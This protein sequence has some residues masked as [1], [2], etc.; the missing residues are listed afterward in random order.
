M[1]PI[2]VAK[3]RPSVGQA[4][5]LPK[6]QDRKLEA[7]GTNTGPVSA[8]PWGSASILTISWMYIALM[9]AEGL[10]QAT[11]VAILN[12][13]YIARR[14][15][16][17]FPV[18][19][20]GHGNLVAHECILDLR[21]WKNRAGIEVE[22]VAKRLI[23][24]GFHAPTMS[25]PVPGTLMVEPTESESKA[26]LDRFCDAMIS[27]HAEMKAIESGEMDRVNNPLRNAPHTA[28]ALISGKWDRPYTRDQAAFPASWTR[29][30]KFW[31]AV[32]RVDNV[33]GDRHLVCSCLPLE[34]YTESK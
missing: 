33:Y 25:W 3:H 14:L 13:N 23:D 10:T 15:E 21:D 8:A 5:S 27:I 32:G 2:G 30:H 4:S 20:K 26:E 6:T 29:E 1:G 22:D 11:K 19:Y 16:P 9:G 18:L 34:A 28:H 12:A 17:Y 7:C 24:Y 31:P